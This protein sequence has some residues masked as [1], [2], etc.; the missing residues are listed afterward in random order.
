MSPSIPATP[1]DTKV[2]QV[3]A[4]DP[5]LYKLL[6][7]TANA[8][9]SLAL[10]NQ[11]HL[12][13][14]MMLANSGNQDAI[15]KVYGSAGQPDWTANRQ[16]PTNPD[17]RLS[18]YS[19]YPSAPAQPAGGQIFPAA[20]NQPSQPGS[21]VEKT[22][23]AAH[24]GIMGLATGG[25]PPAPKPQAAKPDP[26][27]NPNLTTAQADYVASMSPAQRAQWSNANQQQR[28]TMLNN[29][30]Q[31]GINPGAGTKEDVAAKNKAP[32]DKAAITSQPTGA[33]GA[34]NVNPND[35]GYDPKTGG[36][37]NPLANTA[38]D[39]LNQTKMPGQYQQA[40]DVFNKA[41]GQL[42]GFNANAGAPQVSAPTASAQQGSA[43]QASATGMDAAN[44]AIERMNSTS[45]QNA[46]MDAA[47]AQR[48]PDMIAQATQAQNA[49]MNAAQAQRTPDMIANATQAQAY[50]AQGPERWNNAQAQSYMDPYIQQSLKSQLG[51]MEDQFAPQM[52]QIQSQA[53]ANKAYGGARGA[54][55]EQQARRNQNQI[56]ANMVNQGLSQAYG[57]GLGAFQNQNQLQ[58]QTALANASAQ[59]QGSQYNASNQQ[60]INA[61]NAQQAQALGLYN[62]GNQ[63]SANQQ[64]ANFQQQGN[65]YNA[66]NQQAMNALNAQQAQALGLYNTS[67]QQNANQQNAAW[68]Q[69]M[70]QFNAG[71]QQA[72]NLANA[73]FGNQGNQY[74]ASNQQ[75]ASMQNAGWQNAASNLNAQLG[76]QASLQNASLGTQ[77]NLANAQN[78]LSASG[79]NAQNYYTGTGQNLNAWNAAGNMGTGLIN[80]GNA[81][82]S[83]N[84]QMFNNFG[85]AGTA[86]QTAKNQWFQQQQDNAKNTIAAP[87]SFA[88]LPGPT[89]NKAAGGFIGYAKGGKVGH[90][91]NRT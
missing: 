15:N 65:Q 30:G 86:L 9:G 34:A 1:T 7:G 36:F 31:G 79:Q 45:A 76:T 14:L 48:T 75:Q 54:I 52:Q 39:V 24:G 88:S 22:Q 74:N 12:S 23:T 83:F 38:L 40:T 44:A 5:K 59:Q 18:G 78:A 69:A 84:N 85:T 10:Q 73:Q 80:A 11:S 56:E 20:P 68:I 70:N 53:A 47:Q 2:T 25:K 81:G 46:R 51:I 91:R 6:Y 43:S 66:S 3:Q 49:S 77:A 35:F 29:A 17:P 21:S 55:Q 57:S 28:S 58:Q 32:G 33:V 19:I 26:H 50:T 62:T 27:N 82:N 60:A 71:N 37:S 8:P 4:M 42:S 64:N 90:W 89:L 41:A 72:A 61:L 13:N 67:N 63:Q 16:A 87:N